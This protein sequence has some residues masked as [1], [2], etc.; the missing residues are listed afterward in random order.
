[1]FR[2]KDSVF[3][4]QPIWQPFCFSDASAG[5]PG[6]GT[7]SGDGGSATPPPAASSPP[8]PNWSEFAASLSGPIET[9]NRELG[10][11]LDTLTGEVR[12]AATPPPAEPPD[13]D[14]MSR[15]ELVA[16]IVSTVGEAIKA[17][18]TE[19]L[20]PVMSQVGSLQE[21]ITT[22]DVRSEIAKLE[23]ANKD[24]ADWKPAMIE[25]ARQPQYAAL[26]ATDLYKLA[27]ASNP[28]RAA[29][30]NLKY[31]PPPPPARPIWSGLTSARPNGAATVL[32]GRDAGIEAYREV[33]AR[34]PG[35][36]AALME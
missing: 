20:A 36:L 15:P 27:K 1:M 21:R 3:S 17:H 2:F 35:V 11:K 16:H 9:L 5:A 10:S 28:E 14:T 12:T 6:G 33:S 26:G 4:W 34:H 22:N 24:F 18:L 7:G 23:G 32:S 31:N 30:L 25:L 29:E 13:L 8:Q 19:Q